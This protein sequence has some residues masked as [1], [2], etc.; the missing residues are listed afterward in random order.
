MDLYQRYT[1]DER[2]S[3]SLKALSEIFRNPQMTEEEEWTK[4]YLYEELQKVSAKTQGVAL[5][6]KDVVRY[7]EAAELFNE[8]MI[9]VPE[10]EM[11]GGRLSVNYTTDNS[12]GIR[13]AKDDC[14]MDITVEE[15]G[16]YKAEIG[17]HEELGFV[18]ELELSLNGPE[19]LSDKSMVA[20]TF[21]G[22]LALAIENLYKDIA[23]ENIIIDSEK[24]FPDVKVNEPEKEIKNKGKADKK[25]NRPAQEGPEI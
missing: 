8:C 18:K 3:K 2:F 1:S 10:F 5:N 21:I 12:T 25:E 4:M 14:I 19:T 23:I 16:S 20:D 13:F 15:T 24:R 11:E 7:A 22:A 17:H 6:L 9:D